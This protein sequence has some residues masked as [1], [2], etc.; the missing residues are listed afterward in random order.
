MSF[1][2]GKANRKGKV[3]RKPS[4]EG[5]GENPA[6]VQALADQY[7]RRGYTRQ[8]AYAKARKDLGV[9]Y[10]RHTKRMLQGGAARPK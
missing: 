6:G 5:D 4:L 2:Q 8:R 10:R 7:I 1:K 9:E 3:Y